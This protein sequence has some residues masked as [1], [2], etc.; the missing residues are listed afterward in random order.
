M[1]HY[2][3]LKNTTRYGSAHFYVDDKLALQVIGDSMIAWA[4]GDTWAKK[5]KTMTGVTNSNSISIELCVNSD[6]NYN[7]AYNNT[8]ELTKNLM[9]KFNIPATNVVRHFDATGKPCPNSMKTNNW[10]KW[11]EFKELIK[12][13]MVLKIDLSKSSDAVFVGDNNNNNNNNGGNEVEKPKYIR[14]FIHG[15]EAKSVTIKD[16]KSFLWME[17]IGKLVPLIEFFEIL[18]LKVEERPYKNATAIFVEK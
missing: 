15:I 12:Q 14:L 4:I 16:G 8:V 9:K 2:S 6:S 13:P 17:S 18:G 7:E 1:G 10:K 3:Y 11:W 5:N